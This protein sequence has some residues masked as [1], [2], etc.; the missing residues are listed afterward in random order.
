VH[1]LWFPRHIYP[2]RFSQAA[3]PIII[4]QNRRVLG[5]FKIKCII[6]LTTFHSWS[7][8]IDPKQH[9]SPKHTKR[10]WHTQRTTRLHESRFN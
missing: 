6:C 8:Q 7:G 1:T 10:S 3:I 9:L 4:G 2:L 5:I